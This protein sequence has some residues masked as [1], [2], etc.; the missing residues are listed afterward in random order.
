MYSKQN[1][2]EIPWEEYSFF[3]RSIIKIKVLDEVYQA[4]ME[5]CQKCIIV[6]DYPVTENQMFFYAI[7]VNLTKKF[8]VDRDT[9]VSASC[10]Q[11]RG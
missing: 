5:K 6:V 7:D 4:R 9:N 11:K 3:T 2:K 8:N 10:E 1:F